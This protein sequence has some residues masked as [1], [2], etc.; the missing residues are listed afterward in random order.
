MSEAP[1]AP[2]PWVAEYTDD[3][4]LFYTNQETQ[5]TAWE[6]PYDES[7][8]GGA[9][10]GYWGGDGE[11]YPDHAGGIEAD[12]EEVPPAVNPWGGVVTAGPPA[13]KEGEKAYIVSQSALFVACEKRDEERIFELLLAAYNAQN[14]LW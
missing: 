6:L 9:E 11:W 13:A 12:I 4:V 3:G 10:G 8:G 7:G 2:W 1:E 5:E 14:E